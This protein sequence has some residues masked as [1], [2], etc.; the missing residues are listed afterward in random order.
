[1]NG[2]HRIPDQP[3]ILST[4]IPAVALV[5]RLTGVSVD[6]SAPT[7]HDGS[8]SAETHVREVDA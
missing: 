1:M 4:L 6:Q 7:R 2:R 3:D 8:Q 5:Q